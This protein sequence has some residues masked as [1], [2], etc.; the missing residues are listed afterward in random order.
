VKDEIVYELTFD[1][2]DGEQWQYRL[3]DEAEAEWKTKALGQPDAVWEFP[4]RL[5][6]GF[7]LYP[8]RNI[9]H[10]HLTKRIAE[11]PA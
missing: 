5:G 3:K 1:T 2:A 6:D 10:A 9:T 11:Q 8:V 7:D 4:N